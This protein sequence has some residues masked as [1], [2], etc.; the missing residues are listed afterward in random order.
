MT[1]NH[2][3]SSDAIKHGLDGDVLILTE[4]TA[5]RI[6]NR[7]G[8]DSLDGFYFSWIKGKQNVTWKPLS[9]IFGEKKS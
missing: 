5:K 7:E 4:G 8:S 2:T 9:V 6:G 1:D 3:K